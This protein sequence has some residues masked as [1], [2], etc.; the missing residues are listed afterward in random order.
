[1][2]NSYNYQ[3]QHR[4]WL[5]TCENDSLLQ[6]RGKKE[7]VAYRKIIISVFDMGSW[8]VIVLTFIF[9]SVQVL[10][11][12]LSELSKQPAD[13]C[14]IRGLF[15]EGARWDPIK[16]MLAESRPK[17]LY[18][19]VP[20]IWLIPT[21]NRKNPDKGI[22]EC[23]VYKT[24]TRAGNSPVLITVSNLTLQSKHLLQKKGIGIKSESLVREVFNIQVL[25]T[26]FA[27]QIL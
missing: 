3:T 26:V 23:P 1:M 24:L 12:S 6:T 14:Y 5:V 4:L 13:G 27:G 9:I 10:R 25:T 20:V 22:Y 21:A 8:T 7:G 16:Q 15:L 11:E 17:E 19:D 18:V 2:K